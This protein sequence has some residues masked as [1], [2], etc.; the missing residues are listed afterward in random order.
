MKTPRER[1][2]GRRRYAKSRRSNELPRP[3]SAPP[4]EYQRTPGRPTPLCEESSV[5]PN[6]SIHQPP[7]IIIA[8]GEFG[9]DLSL[10]FSPGFLQRLL[11]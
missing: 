3:T 2:A 4:P 5:G 8:L 6:R 10:C 11:A 1:P 7:L 9:I